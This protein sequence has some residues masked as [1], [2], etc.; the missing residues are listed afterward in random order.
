MSERARKMG[1]RSFLDKEMEV[2]MTKR[3]KMSSLTV[4]YDNPMA[5]SMGKK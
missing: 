5:Y 3:W 2:S 1:R 4:Q